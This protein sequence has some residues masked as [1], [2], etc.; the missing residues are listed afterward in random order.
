MQTI[1]EIII[2]LMNPRKNV[3]HVVQDD[4]VRHIRLILLHNNAPFDPTPPSGDTD[5]LHC[6]VEFRKPDGNGGI[7]DTTS[8]GETAVRLEDPDAAHGNVFIVALDGQ[9]FTC[10]GQTQ[11]NIRFEM[12]SGKKIHTFS[13]IADVEPTAS[14]DVESI[15]WGSLTS[16]SDLRTAVSNATSSLSALSATVNGEVKLENYERADLSD[17]DI[18]EGKSIST[19]S[20]SPVT[21]SAYT[22]IATFIPVTTGTVIKKGSL[23][24]YIVFFSNAYNTAISSSTSSSRNDYVCASNGFVKIA[25]KLDPASSTAPTVTQ[26]KENIQVIYPNTVRKA[27]ATMKNIISESSVIQNKYVAYNDGSQNGTTKYS[28]TQKIDVDSSKDYYVSITDVSPDSNTRDF[29][30]FAYDVDGNYIVSSE[31]YDNSN[32]YKAYYRAQLG[33]STTSLFRVFRFPSNVKQIAVMFD[34]FGTTELSIKTAF[35]ADYIA[36]QEIAALRSEL[37]D[38]S[39]RCYIT[40]KSNPV[41]VQQIIDVAGSYYAEGGKSYIDGGVTKFYMKYGYNTVLSNTYNGEGGIDCSAYIGLVLRG[42]HFEDTEYYTD[43]A[44]ATSPETEEDDGTENTGTTYDANPDYDW[45]VNPYDYELPAV[46]NAPAESASKVRNA[47]QL[48]Q[49]LQLM[50]RSVWID[51]H[52]ANLLPGDV[53]FFSKKKQNGSWI[54]EPRY[55]HISHVAIVATKEDAP[56]DATWDTEL[57]PYQHTLYEVRGAAPQHPGA[58]GKFVLENPAFSGP[59]ENGVDTLVLVCR[60]DLGRITPT[61][62]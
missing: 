47:A 53:V 61:S 18:R 56:A 41:Y 1:Q 16:I 32:D 5:T 3:I 29:C 15:T 45:S 60:P 17:F 10:P 23:S 52:L 39:K 46:V 4:S 40:E 33:L 49:W 25:T 30:I 2:D 50:G 22:S 12:E 34:K 6:F 42:I 19:T 48:G 35:E 7:Y 54:Q 43:P 8:L 31:Y 58:C 44:N 9:C 11:I 20:G 38:L 59:T 27:P 57:Y 26:V 62:D 21:A 13:I 36:R 55:M 37:N 24:A 14:S 28:M 51:K